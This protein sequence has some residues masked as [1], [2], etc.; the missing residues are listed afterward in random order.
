[1][2]IILLLYSDEDGMTKLVE[3]NDGWA[4]GLY[5]GSCSASDYLKLLEARWE[6]LIDGKERS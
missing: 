4:L 2:N 3:V 6:E 5:K 1:M